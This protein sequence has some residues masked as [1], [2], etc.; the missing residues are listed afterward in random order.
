MPPVLNR[1]AARGRGRPLG[2]GHIGRGGRPTTERG[3]AAARAEALAAR[4]ARGGV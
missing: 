3:R 4:A 2:R 1:A